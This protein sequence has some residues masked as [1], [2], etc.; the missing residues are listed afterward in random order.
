MPKAALVTNG[1]PKIGGAVFVAPVGTTLPTDATTALATAF[2]ELGYC[3]EDGLTNSNAP[4][5]DTI[6]A[7]GGDPVLNTQSARPDTFNLTL[8]EILNVDVLK[9]VYGEDNVTGDLET[10]I[11][12]KV[13]SSDQQ[14]PHVFVVDMVLKG[15]VAKRIVVPSA[16]LTDLDDITYDD[17]DASGYGCTFSCTPDSDGYTHYEYI[18]GG[19]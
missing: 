6:N 9:T 2:K 16:T 17:S 15:G 11:A 5:T 12:L 1:K 14:I 13:S 10:G 18:K 8:L 4:D 19:K 7:W 3:S